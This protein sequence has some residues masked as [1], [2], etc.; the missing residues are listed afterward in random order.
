M[1]EVEVEPSDSASNIRYKTR[2]KTRNSI[3]TS[4]RS[5]AK[6]TTLSN[7]A[8]AAAKRA[9]LVAEVTVLKEHRALE[10]QELYLKH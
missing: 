2:S 1:S 10:E 8:V 7:V 4:Q 9:A 6:S 5:Q 3:V